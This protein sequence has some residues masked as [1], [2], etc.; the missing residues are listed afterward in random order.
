MNNYIVD[1]IILECMLCHQSLGMCNVS[2]PYPLHCLRYWTNTFFKAVG[3]RCCL[4]TYNLNI[5]L[6]VMGLVLGQSWMVVSIYRR[7]PVLFRSFFPL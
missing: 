3:V 2:D 4:Q 7:Y 5:N 1:D 6:E